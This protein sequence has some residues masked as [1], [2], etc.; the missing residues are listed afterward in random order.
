MTA[1]IIINALPR[2]GAP[3]SVAE[4]KHQLRAGGW[5]D[6]EIDQGLLQAFDAFAVTLGRHDFPVILTDAEKAGMVKDHMGNW[7]CLAARR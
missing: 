1:D 3:V 5:S 6:C 7:Y 2:N 4:V